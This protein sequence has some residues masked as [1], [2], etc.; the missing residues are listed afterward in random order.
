MWDLTL[1]ENFSNKFKK[2]YFFNE[3]FKFNEDMYIFNELK[4]VPNHFSEENSSLILIKT[5]DIHKVENFLHFL[6]NRNISIM[7][8][9]D[10]INIEIRG[11]ERRSSLLFLGKIIYTLYPKLIT[12]EIEIPQIFIVRNIKNTMKS[13]RNIANI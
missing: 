6:K 11:C 13:N 10:E 7:K 9:M 4:Y 1:T 8:N 3:K 5:K 12:D 2:D